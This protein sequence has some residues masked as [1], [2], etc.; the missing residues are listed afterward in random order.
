MDNH[1]KVGVGVIILNDNRVLLLK[2]K[3]AHGDGTWAFVGGHLEF[4]ETPEECAKREVFEEIGLRIIKTKSVAFTN[5]LYNNICA[6]K[7]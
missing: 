4:G 3:N 5:D 6:H 7:I 1:P 2:R